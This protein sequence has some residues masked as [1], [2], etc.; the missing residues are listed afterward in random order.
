MIRLVE[1]C[2]SDAEEDA[3]DLYLGR[4]GGVIGSKFGRDIAS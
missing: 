3:Q 4:G 1:T 2:S